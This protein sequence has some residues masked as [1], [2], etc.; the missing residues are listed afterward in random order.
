MRS[1]FAVTKTGLFLFGFPKILSPGS[2]ESGKS[3]KKVPNTVLKI[4][5]NCN[6]ITPFGQQTIRMN[7]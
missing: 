5:I 7:R 4:S 3:R 6:L 1:K 2:T